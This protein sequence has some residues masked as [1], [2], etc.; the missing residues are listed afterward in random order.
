MEFMEAVQS[1]AQEV[2][3]Q[4]PQEEI[5]PQQ[6]AQR[7]A[8]RAQQDSLVQVLEKA[9]QSY[10]AELKNA[11]HAIDYLKRRGLSG[12]ISSR[13]GLGYAPAGWSH[14]AG[15]FPD[16]ASAQLQE[17]G[18]VVHAEEDGKRYDRFRDRIMFPIRDVKGQCIGFGGRVLGD[19]KPKYLNSPETPLFHKGRELYGL[20]EARSHL[21]DAGY[22]LVCE[23]YMDVVALAQLGF[24]QAVA[25]LGTAC[26]SEHVHKLYRFTEAVIFSFDGDAAGRR[27]ARKALEAVLPLVNDVRSAKFLFLPP[28]HDPDSFIRTHGA[29]AFTRLVHA[30]MPFNQFLLQVA[31]E[32]CDLGTAPGR[33]RLAS[34]AAPLWALLP[35]STLKRLVLGELAQ[36]IALPVAELEALWA[37]PAAQPPSTG[38]MGFTPGFADTGHRGERTRWRPRSA[39]VAAVRPVISANAANQAVRLLLGNM[40]LLER[41]DN[42]DWDALTH[43][44]APHGPLFAWLESHYHAVGVQAWP[45]LQP[46]LD[47]IPAPDAYERPDN[48][49]VQALMDSPLAHPEDEP[50]AQYEELRSILKPWLAQRIRELLTQLAQTYAQDPSNQEVRQRYQ[51]L[52]ARSKAL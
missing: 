13:Y 41:L 24:P 22:A 8:V 40:A 50:E 47:Q 39:P 42:D 31:S 5:S 32:D 36:H 28:E 16:Y 11:P 15:V 10:C 46:H 51:A 26:T 18:L 34:Q 33:A 2:G 7:Q 27:A 38:E 19:E 21:R 20:Y 35:P 45:V 43:L 4:V 6:R 17:A 12:S 37:G 29:D 48:T 9:A 23:G 25:T 30:A 52:Q 3:M 1:L 14:L 49:W 44:P